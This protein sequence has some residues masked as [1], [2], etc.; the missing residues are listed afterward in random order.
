MNCDRRVP[1]RFTEHG[2]GQRSKPGGSHDLPPTIQLRR[3]C[4]CAR[5]AP[6]CL[7]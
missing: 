2:P 1:F 4:G 5:P 6:S 7:R 3:T